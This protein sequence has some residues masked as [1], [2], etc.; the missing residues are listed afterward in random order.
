MRTLCGWNDGI[1][2]SPF[3]GQIIF[4]YYGLETYVVIV[5]GKCLLSHALMSVASGAAV[6][7]HGS[8]MVTQ[9]CLQPLLFILLA[10]RS[11]WSDYV[12]INTGPWSQEP[13][14]GL[15][16]FCLRKW[17]ILIF[18]ALSLCGQLWQIKVSSL[19]I[20]AIAVEFASY[21]LREVL[22]SLVFWMLL[23]F[24]DLRIPLFIQL[25]T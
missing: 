9:R 2:W 1:Q 18:L 11:V 12:V 5:S 3:H 25:F 6:T 7:Q 23:I 17:W 10:G 16:W 8:A 14:N 15:S 24:E 22:K 20:I 21:I 19:F 4:R 13:R